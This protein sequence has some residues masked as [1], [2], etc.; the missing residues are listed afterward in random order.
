M[1][2]FT[3]WDGS[4]QVQITL[5]Y[6]VMKSVIA[7]E[8]I[9]MTLW[10]FRG[11]QSYDEAIWGHFY[12]KIALFHPPFWPLG[13]AGKDLK[14]ILGEFLEPKPHAKFFS[15]PYFEVTGTF[16]PSKLVILALFWGVGEVPQSWPTGLKFEIMHHSGCHYT[17]EVHFC[18]SHHL[19][20][21]P[22]QF[23]K[24][25]QIWVLLPYVALLSHHDHSTPLKVLRCPRYGFPP[26][27]YI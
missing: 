7:M 13:N 8:A 15:G 9:R 10:P 14:I 12:C 22:G 25:G 26:M 23:S 19:G 27:F 11:F 2:Y 16:S 4:Q 24:I 1:H 5:A 17:C 21:H 6:M 3:V 18:W 20:G